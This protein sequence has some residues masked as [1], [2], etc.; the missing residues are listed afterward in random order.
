MID[1]TMIY[2]L[3]KTSYALEAILY[4]LLTCKY[5]CLTLECKRNNK[6]PEDSEEYMRIL[7]VMLRDC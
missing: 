4:E 7:F 3:K 1:Y 2:K 6:E 5:R